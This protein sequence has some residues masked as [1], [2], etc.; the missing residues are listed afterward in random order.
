MSRYRHLSIEERESLLLSIG[1]G[2]TLREIAKILRRS[3]SP[4]SRELK[5][6]CE[7]KR[8]YSPEK[9]A[10]NYRKRRKKCCRH[11]ILKNSAAKALVQYLFLE[12]QWS[13]E[14]IANRLKPEHNEIQVSYAAIYR[15]IYLGDLET[16]K[17]SHGQ[18]GVAGKLR[19][20]G[21]TRRRKGAEERR[22]KIAISH[23]IEEQSDEAQRRTEL[24][25]WEAD[26]AAGKTGS[27]C[28]VTLVD[29]K[30]RFLL[31]RCVSRKAATEVE[32]GMILIPRISC[33]YGG[34]EQAKDCRISNNP[35]QLA[36]RTMRLRGRC[37]YSRALPADDYFTKEKTY[38][39]V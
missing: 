24:G 4:L 19:H 23:P 28:M 13:P 12:Q 20:R 14:R 18:R 33:R 10:K 22:G 34:E 25:H 2:K 3:P 37:N 7:K 26:T 1:E 6:S 29:R 8:D 15:S 35:A 11:R 27:S 16:E 36:D 17:L 39:E 31:G 5:R 38:R 21:K 30:S 32:D 9:A